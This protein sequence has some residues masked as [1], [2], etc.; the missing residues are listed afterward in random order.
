MGARAKRRLAWL[1]GSA[2]ALVVA[3]AAAYHFTGAGGSSSDGPP[4]SSRSHQPLGMESAGIAYGDTPKKVLRALGAPTEKH[5]ACWVY[6]APG[7]RLHGL[8]VGQGVDAMKYC[9]A[10]GPAG[11]EAVSAI[12][13]HRAA[14]TFRNKKYPAR[15]VLP[16]VLGLHEDDYH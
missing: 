13:G 16:D 1:V 7:S 2:G 10:A 5:R 6:S 8:F 4:T 3:G 15:W 11:G 14:F 9:F 12:Y